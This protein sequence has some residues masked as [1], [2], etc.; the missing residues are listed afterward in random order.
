MRPSSYP[1][2]PIS[3][4]VLLSCLRGVT[5]GGTI[6]ITF[7]QTAPQVQTMPLVFTCVNGQ[8]NIPQLTMNVQTSLNGGAAQTPTAATGLPVVNMSWFVAGAGSPVTITNP[9]GVTNSQVNGN[10]WQFALQDNML[11]ITTDVSVGS[12]IDGQTQPAIQVAFSTNTL[13]NTTANTLLG[14]PAISAV[15][16]LV[17]QF[18]PANVFT[19]TPTAAPTTPTA[20]APSAVAPTVAPALSVMPT[21][22]LQQPTSP[23]NNNSPSAAIGAGVAVA[24]VLLVGSAIA[25]YVARKRRRRTPVIDSEPRSTSILL[26]RDEDELGNADWKKKSFMESQKEKSTRKPSLPVPRNQ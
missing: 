17:N 11:T 2:V 4:L 13:V 12:C 18:N 6:S 8:W 24:A 19:F 3:L 22:L 20:A 14:I 15:P 25:V 16:Q 26:K 5:S 23:G 7:T 10:V 21:S 9:V 1:V